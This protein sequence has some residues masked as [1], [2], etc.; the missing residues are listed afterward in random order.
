M[1]GM[2]QQNSSKIKYHLN[3]LV[4]VLEGSVA[5][6]NNEQTRE[7]ARPTKEIVF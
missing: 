2:D 4:S 5:A 1:H 7:A 6:S 3:C